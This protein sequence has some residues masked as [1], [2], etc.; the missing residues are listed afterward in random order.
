MKLHCV[1]TPARQARHAGERRRE[2]STEQSMVERARQIASYSRLQDVATAAAPECLADVLFVV[3]HAHK[4]HRSTR[5]GLPQRSK[6]LKAVHPRH[7]DVEYDDVWIGL[8]CRIQPLP[9]VGGET[10]YIKIVGEHLGDS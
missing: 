9:A 5:S 6:G 7:V 2:C 10:C 3:D 1:T 8:R 4:H